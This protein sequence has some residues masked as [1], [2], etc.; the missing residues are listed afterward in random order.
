MS[1]NDSNGEG[2]NICG[3]R[4]QDGGMC[5]HP[6]GT[7]T[8]HYGSGRCYLHG[9]REAGM[10]VAKILSI[11]ARDPLLAKRAQVYLNSDRELLNAR[12]ELAVLKGRFET[13]HTD[14]EDDSDVPKLCQ[15]ANTISLM[16]R[17]IQDIEITRKHYIHIDVLTRFTADFSRIGQEFFPDISIRERFIDALEASIKDTIPRSNARGI[18]ARLMTRDAQDVIVDVED[19]EVIEGRD[20][21]EC[22]GQVT[23]R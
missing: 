20:E 3:A 13:M 7:G 15:L 8:E 2:R 23:P 21:E 4:K 22:T 9:P 5:I 12:R 1:K 11:V 18:A 16:T 19:Y 14:V 6:A 17:R 10:G